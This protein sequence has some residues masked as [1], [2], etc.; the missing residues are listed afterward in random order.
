MKQNGRHPVRN[1]IFDLGKVL[2]DFEPERCMEA[3]GFSEA[4]KEAFRQKIFSDLW[5]RCDR[6]PYDDTQIR[7]LF[8]AYVPGF[9]EEVDRLWDDLFAITRVMPYTEAW[10]KSLKDRGFH[11]YILS[12]YGRRAYELNSPRYGFLSLTDGQL[13][14]YEIQSIKPEPKIYRTL[15]RR[16]AICP[17]E[18]VFLDDRP[19]N[20]ETARQLGFRGIVFESYEK[21]SASLE[22]MLDEA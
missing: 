14:S 1:I 16:F 7:T 17:E 21:A 18:S 8:K 12:N 3:L 4:A 15:C 5:L 9:K 2:V 20:V 11:L 19:E 22:K 6:I 10:L 13:I